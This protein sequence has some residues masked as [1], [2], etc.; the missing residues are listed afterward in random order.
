MI[1]QTMSDDNKTFEAFR[2]VNIAYNTYMEYGEEILK[3]FKK[4]TKFPYFNRVVFDDDRGNRWHV[5]FECQ[6]KKFAKKN[7]MRSFCYTIY[8]VFGK[9]GNSGKGVMLF[10]TCQMYDW[11][12]NRE[13]T[14]RMAT[15]MDIVP[16]AFNRFTERYLKPLGKDNVEFERKV[17]L[18]MSNWL[19]FDV[20]GDK[21]SEKHTD[22]G[23]Y[24]YDV[25]MKN[26]GILRGNVVNDI[27]IRFFTFV[28]KDMLFDEQTEWHKE[29]QS[30]LWSAR[31]RGIII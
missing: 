8:N 4:G 20:G 21:S 13:E 23:E 19:Y 1:L 5:I 26:G 2:I 31:R 18:L 11:V 27:L 30:E 28:S 29:M 3:R 14:D 15:F 25:F 6:S 7:L 16:H 24:P 12:N 22:K 17:E 10:D 9:K